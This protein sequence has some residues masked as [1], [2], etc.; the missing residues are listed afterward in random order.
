[1]AKE[2]GKADSSNTTRTVRTIGIDT[3]KKLDID[4]LPELKRIRQFISAQVDAMAKRYI[5][6]RGERI[7]DNDAVQ[8]FFIDVH[9]RYLQSADIA[10]ELYRF[11]I[12]ESNKLDAL[13]DGIRHKAGEAIGEFNSNKNAYFLAVDHMRSA[14]EGLNGEAMYFELDNELTSYE[15]DIPDNIYRGACAGMWQV[16]KND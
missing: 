11:F 14:Y 13:Y 7:L 9:N 8:A 5:D 6:P 2:I 12:E 4:D 10:P 3:T 16:A 15:P 1:M